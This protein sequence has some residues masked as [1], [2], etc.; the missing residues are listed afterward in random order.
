MH[1]RDNQN[2]NIGTGGSTIKQAADLKHLTTFTQD[3]G[4][5]TE[6]DIRCDKANQVVS[7]LAP[8]L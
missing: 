4:T 6:N 7:Q 8:L 5:D 2:L 1:G 3:G